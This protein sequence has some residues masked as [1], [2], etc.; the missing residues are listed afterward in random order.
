MNLEYTENFD[1]I[2]TFE[3]FFKSTLMKGENFMIP[4]I[5]VGIS[6]H[7]LNPS[8]NLLHLNYSYIVCTGVLFIK[9]NGN[10]IY[11]ETYGKFDT[12]QIVY[13]GGTDLSI[14]VNIEYQVICKNAFLQINEKTKLSKEFWVPTQSAKNN[15]DKQEVE[16]F[17]LLKNLPENLNSM[18]C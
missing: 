12:C 18:F 3:S 5:N 8:N 14:N 2:T 10:I 15:M 17:F 6:D 16:D 13:L 11:D 1:E 9:Y 4:Y 7:P